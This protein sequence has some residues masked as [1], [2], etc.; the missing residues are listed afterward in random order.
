[1]AFD[2]EILRIAQAAL[3]V[4]TS[5][6]ADWLPDGRLKVH[7]YWPTNLVRGDR[8]LGS[9]RINVRTGAW[10][11]FAS[12]DN[13]GDLVSLQ[14]FVRGCRQGQAARLIAQQ[15]GVAGAGERSTQ[16]GLAAHSAHQH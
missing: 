8:L 3:A 4:A 10:H 16:D 7:E 2:L 6:L 11:D 1:M 9:F 13:G 5:L 15:L 14:A 12:G